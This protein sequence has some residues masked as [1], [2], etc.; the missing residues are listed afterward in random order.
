[1][2][3]YEKYRIIHHCPKCSWFLSDVTAFYRGPEGDAEIIL[4]EG[5]CKR[6]G[7]V[8]PVDWDYDDFFYHQLIKT[9]NAPQA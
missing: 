8:N 2:P 1:M 5:K 4:V 6:H 3:T 9:D 7:I